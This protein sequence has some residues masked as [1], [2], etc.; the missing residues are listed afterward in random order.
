MSLAPKKR[1]RGVSWSKQAGRWHVSIKAAGRT[2]FVGSFEN[3]REAAIAYDRVAR[4]LHGERAVLNLPHVAS[5]KATPSAIKAERASRFK[6]ETSSKYR[7][8]TWSK[9]FDAWIAQIAHANEHHRIGQF[10]D[11]REAARAYDRAAAA[12]HGRKA[13]LNF[14]NDR[15][16]VPALPEEI[17][18]ERYRATKEHT[19]SRYRGVTWSEVHGKWVAG[20][21]LANTRVA[22]GQFEE[23]EEAALA[24][25]R[26]MLG[27]GA[28]RAL[29]NF[30][31]EDTKPATARQVRRE[32]RE[33]FKEKTTS[34]FRG[35]YW[36][37]RSGKWVAQIVAERPHFLGH[38]DDERLA[39][40]TYDRAALHFHGEAAKLNFP[41]RSIEPASPEVL[42]RER[43]AHAKKKTSSR[44][45]GVTSLRS[46][47]AWVAQ[48]SIDNRQV[49]LG[50]FEREE[51]AARAY[52]RAA[53]KHRGARAKLNF[54]PPAHDR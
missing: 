35:V 44:F 16:L 11:E 34:R 50:V 9:H 22:L 2:H 29:L 45:R 13:K 31:D 28:E 30:P 14:P 8:V 5:G 51:D 24:F 26:V 4:E 38:F 3:D 39:A 46:R 49:H 21:N 54:P 36:E 42:L 47:G 10:D 27:L 33:A 53:R 37:T 17:A 41:N 43:A 32:V 40:C 48:I 52:D 6:R 15:S 18:R 19:H 12:L 23:E 1:Y 7:G 25:D 20:V